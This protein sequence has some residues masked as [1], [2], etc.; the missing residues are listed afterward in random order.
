MN[1]SHIKINNMYLDNRWGGFYLM[2]T[3]GFKTVQ[4][5]IVILFFLQTLK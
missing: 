1:R 5:K 2:M 4:T 3:F